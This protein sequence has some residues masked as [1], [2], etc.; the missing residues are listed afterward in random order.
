MLVRRGA[1]AKAEEGSGGKF[2]GTVWV[3]GGISAPEPSLIGVVVV[4]F[5]PGSRTFWHSHR[6]GQFIYVLAGRG[7]TASEGDS[8]IEILPGDIVWVGPGERHWHGAAADSPMVHFAVNVG[9]GPD[10]GNE[11]T[12]EE[13]SAGH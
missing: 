10:W 12:D 8:R 13:Y 11:V 7:H 5:E 4:H 6:E 3:D 9:G 1:E 2:T